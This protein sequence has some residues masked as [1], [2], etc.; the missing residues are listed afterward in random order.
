M[1]GEKKHA[2]TS[3]KRLES[4]RKGQVSKSQ[5]LLRLGAMVV[6]FE[7]LRFFFYDIQSG[8]AY[9][10]RLPSTIFSND[11]LESIE[12]IITESLQILYGIAGGV[13]IVII[14]VTILVNWFQHGLV[15]NKESIKPN[16]QSLNP[17]TQVKSN[18][19]QKKLW[20]VFSTV[21]KV[22]ILFGFGLLLAWYLMPDI[23]LSAHLQSDY[24]LAAL[25]EIILVAERVI[26]LA[27]LILAIIDFLVQRKINEGKIKMSDQELKDER[28]NMEGNPE[29]KSKVKEEAKKMMQKSSSDPL[30]S[31][32]EANAL[33]LNPTHIAIGLMY[34]EGVTPLPVVVYKGTDN[35]VKNAITE[36]H[37]H[38]IPVIRYLWLARS[39]YS[40][41]D[42]GVSIP[43]ES[44]TAVASVYRTIK[45]LDK[46]EPEIK[47]DEYGGDIYE[48]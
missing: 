2:A 40:E 21:F 38:K 7:M 31:L 1:S 6:G 34:E 20:E 13:L 16:F 46:V 23:I 47:Y 10:F 3:K 24:I 41:S 14:V 25:L 30:E 33:I 35:E 11:F 44:I 36:A 26:I 27:L 4:K 15:L 17:V 8:F 39:L 43:R 5:D 9:L 29:M 19:S 37:K 42:I 18:F 12:I 45:D 22:I 48:L 28:K 32:K